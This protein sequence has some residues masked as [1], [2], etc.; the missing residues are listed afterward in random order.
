MENTQVVN[1][2]HERF[3]RCAGCP[4]AYGPKSKMPHIKSLY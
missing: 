3:S 2:R 4:T 1:E